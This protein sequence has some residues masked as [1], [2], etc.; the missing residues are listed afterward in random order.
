M[1]DGLEPVADDELLYRRVSEASEWYDPATGE[2]S[3]QAF[4]PHKTEDQTGLSV[5]RS[6]YKT[7]EQ[8]GVG[9]PGKTYFVAVL[10]AGEVKSAGIAVEPR[11]HVPGGYDPGHAELPDLNSQN[12]GADDTLERQRKLVELCIEIKGPFETPP[13]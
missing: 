7:P 2:L 10:R 12:R 4:A 9:R 11:P 1:A 5:S 6:K 8:A 3:P 13:A